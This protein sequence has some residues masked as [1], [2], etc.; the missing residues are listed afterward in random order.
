MKPPEG[1]SHDPNLVCKLKKSLYGLKQASR[2]WFAKLTL[3][4]LDQGFLQSMNDYSLFTK[5]TASSFTIVAVYV[6]DLIVTGSDSS[7]IQSLKHHLHRAFSIKDLGSLH[8]FLGLEV[9]H[10]ATGIAIT[11]RKF[12]KELLQN[13]GISHFKK[14]VTPLPFNLKLHVDDSP[15]YSNPTHYRSLVGKLNFLT[16]TRPDLSFTVQTLS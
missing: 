4:L 6:D 1:L 14:A 5:R 15:L 11:Q 12:A 16:N 13:S 7:V 8:Y 2:Q 3:A 10:L 9:S